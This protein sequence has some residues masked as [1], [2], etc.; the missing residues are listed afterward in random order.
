MLYGERGLVAIEVKRSA[1]FREADLATL[2][3]FVGDDPVARCLVLL[4][5]E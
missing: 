4:G 2:K 1:H 3:L 5:G